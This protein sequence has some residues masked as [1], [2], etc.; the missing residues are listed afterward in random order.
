MFSQ[1]FFKKTSKKCVFL[2]F[3]GC[4]GRIYGG[5]RGEFE[6]LL[7]LQIMNQKSQ[8]W[9]CYLFF[10]CKLQFIQLR[11]ENGELR[12]MICMIVNHIDYNILNKVIIARLCR[13]PQ[14]ELSNFKSQLSTS[15]DKF[16]FIGDITNGFALFACKFLVRR[17]Q[18]FF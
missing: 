18:F 11:V 14:Q 17:E 12:V 16:L 2:C 9:L 7:Y 8:L 3:L 13:L 6:V 15:L 10:F 1:L 4:L 5:F